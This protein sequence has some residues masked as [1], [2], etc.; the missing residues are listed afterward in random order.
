MPAQ[1]TV[2][3]VEQQP[4]FWGSEPVACVCP[5]CRNSVVTSPVASP[6]LLSWLA[7]AGLC[8]VGLWPCAPIPF[9]V[10]GCQDVRHYC[11][12]CG[13]CIRTREAMG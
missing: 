3:V 1:Q 7:C 11:P 12:A 4:A 13:V 2:L 6:G 5:N 8:L 10:A 9:C